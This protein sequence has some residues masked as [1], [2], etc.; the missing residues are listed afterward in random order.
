MSFQFSKTTLILAAA[1][2]LSA[3]STIAHK[4]PDEMVRYG[5]Q[6]NLVH[7]NQYNFEGE[8]R[9]KV[10]PATPPAV[11]AAQTREAAAQVNQAT[12]E[13]ARAAAAVPSNKRLGYYSKSRTMVK[14]EKSAEFNRKL[15]QAENDRIQYQDKALYYYIHNLQD[16]ITTHLT[17]PYK[18]AVD[19]RQGRLEFVPEIRY[20]GR[21]II[22]AAAVPTQADLKNMTMILDP[23]AIAP[24]WDAYAK[25]VKPNEVIGDKYLA[26]QVPRS[27]YQ[28]LPVKQ[29]IRAVPKAVDDGYASINK[30]AYTLEPMDDAGRE[31]GASYHVRLS[32]TPDQSE[33]VT[34]V[35][36]QSLSNQLKQNE[37]DA[38]QRSSHGQTADYAKMQDLL[39]KI[40]QF[41]RSDVI[42]DPNVL[43]QKLRKQPVVTDFYLDRRGRIVALRQTLNLTPLA[44]FV[45]SSSKVYAT[46]WTKLHYTARPEFIMQPNQGNTLDLTQR[47]INLHKTPPTQQTL[48]ADTVIQRLL[49]LQREYPNNIQVKVD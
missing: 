17:A 25:V 24:W 18:G 42:N 14:K 6:K 47:I 29:L 32:I 4:S 33:Q 31:A 26:V 49:D 21:N 15:N 45:G 10:I 2:F 39:Q 20:Q 37:A 9:L 1:G 5:V 38:L 12:A 11:Q 43:V 36:L 30:N 8:Y 34:M 48:N 41:L 3:C 19:L 13:A 28:N 7:D 23:A 27:Q 16:V 35:M 40:G 44:K 46:S 22:A